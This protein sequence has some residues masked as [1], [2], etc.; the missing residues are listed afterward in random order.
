VPGVSGAPGLASGPLLTAMRPAGRRGRVLGGTQEDIRRHNLATLLG[1]LHLSGPLSRADLTGLMGLNRSTIAALVAELAALGAVREDRPERTQSGAGRPSLM[2]H[3]CP[4]AVQ[5]LAAHVGVDRVE[6]ALFGIGGQVMARR[7]RRLARS[8]PE[9]VTGLVAT[10]AR[11]LLASP[12]IGRVV[13]MGVS[14]PGVV[15]REDGRVRFAPNLGWNETPLG[16]LLAARVAPIPVQLGND[17]DLGALAE[18]SRGVARDVDDVVFVAAETGVGGGIILGG[19]PLLGVGGYAGELG[20]MKVREDGQRCRCGARGCWETEIG[21]EA[22]AR[23]LGLPQQAD[24]VTQEA[25][26]QA[27]R[28]ATPATTPALEQVGHYLGL[29]LANVVNLLNPRLLILGGLLRDLYPLVGEQVRR[30]LTEAAL[31]APAEQVAL[32]VPQLGGDAVLAGAAELAWHD[33]LSD[34]AAVLSA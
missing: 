13:A 28:R 9:A 33:L 11:T 23:A 7:R 18:H 1:H 25:V 27:L 4:R 6:V 34:P 17:A 3:T 2:V 31:P 12:E 29:G 22:V 8:T 20:H 15:G 26:A 14:V 5:V 24:G 32:T 10:L 16:E 30:S 21:A 19:R